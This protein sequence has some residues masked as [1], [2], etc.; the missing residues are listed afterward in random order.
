MFIRYTPPFGT[1][2]LIGSLAVMQDVRKEIGKW[3]LLPV[4]MT[5]FMKLRQ[6]RT[7]AFSRGI[8]TSGGSH[9]QISLQV[10]YNS[11]RFCI[12]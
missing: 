9:K 10:A 6:I 1:N 8:I 12:F 11:G 2:S 7:G 4:T 3:K 5:L